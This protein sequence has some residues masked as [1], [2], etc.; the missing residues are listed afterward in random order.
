MGQPAIK[1]GDQMTATDM[2]V[3][4]VPSA[5]GPTPTPLPHP[6]NGTVTGNLS[7]D[8]RVNGRPAATVGSTAVNTPPHTPTPP[9]TGFQTAPTN[10]GTITSGSSSVRI[11]GKPATRVGDQAQTCADPAPNPAAQLVTADNTVLIGG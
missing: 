8:V 7:P 10:Q 5:T 4:L 11:N 1:Q 6:F 3:V 2:H 9:G